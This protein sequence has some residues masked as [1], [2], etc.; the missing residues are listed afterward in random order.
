MTTELFQSMQRTITN[1]LNEGIIT[2]DTKAQ[3]LG[4]LFELEGDM[5]T[6][7]VFSM[8]PLYD[9]GAQSNFIQWL[10]ALT[11]VGHKGTLK[12]C[13]WACVEND[14]RGRPGC[15]IVVETQFGT[16]ESK[17]YPISQGAH[18][19]E[20]A[21][22]ASRDAA[23]PAHCDWFSLIDRPKKEYAY[24]TFGT[25]LHNRSVFEGLHTA[26][27]VRLG[28]LSYPHQLDAAQMNDENI[29]K[30]IAR[31]KATMEWFSTALMVSLQIHIGLLKIWNKKMRNEI[32]KLQDMNITLDMNDTG[33]T[34]H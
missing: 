33:S 16:T 11:C 14:V 9:N 20:I 19:Y 29:T 22:T 34:L 12:A 2:F 1:T 24:L 26:L 15:T 30:C 17:W 13:A 10:P 21:Q 23:V 18:G 28:L 4:L 32:S 7:V 8:I 6:P 25:P 31:N 5:P 3:F 27:A